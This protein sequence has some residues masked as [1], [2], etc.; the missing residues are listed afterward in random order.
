MYKLIKQ[1]DS[2]LGVYELLRRLPYS[3]LKQ[4]IICSS[5]NVSFKQ[6]IVRSKCSSYRHKFET[7]YYSFKLFM[8]QTCMNIVCNCC[9]SRCTGN[10]Q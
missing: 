9:N 3:T 5:S 4:T 2:N 8:L 6:T 1:N 7:D 10:W